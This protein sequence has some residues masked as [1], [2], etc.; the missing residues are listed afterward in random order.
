M[1]KL[2]VVTGGSGFIGI[3]LIERLVE[4]DFDVINIDINA[5]K[6]K[7]QDR[8]FERV[9]I[10]N[11]EALTLFFNNNEPHYV[12]NLA[13][14]TDLNGKLISDYSVNMKGVENLCLCLQGKKNLKKI[15]F[16]SSMLVCRAG[17]IPLKNN[18]FSADTLYGKSK[19]EGENIIRKYANNIPEFYIFRPTSIWGPWFQSPYRDFF[20]LCLSK[21][22]FKIG[23]KSSSKT[24]GF[25]GNAVNQIISLLDNKDLTVTSESLIYL[26][27][28]EPL[29]AD[30]WAVKICEAA[31]IRGPFRIPFFLIRCGGFFG[32]FLDK[33]N[34]KFPLTSFR[35]RNMTTNNIFKKKQ[36]CITNKYKEYTVD[37]GIKLTL[38]WLERDRSKL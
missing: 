11:K 13:A 31:Q 25:V 18:D 26:G 9:D 35:V 8:F 37:E 12:I 34:F 10:T 23:H 7:S 15:L 22:Y 24:Y 2:V 14:R 3:N 16:A 32:D 30:K 20:D 1:K 38:E 27:D 21:K 6:N 17:H 29:N 19:A 4:L 36:L 33:L 5:S 28:L